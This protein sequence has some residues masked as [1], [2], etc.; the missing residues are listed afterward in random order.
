[1]IDLADRRAEGGH[2]IGGI[3]VEDAQKILVLKILLRLHAASGQEGV[4]DADGCGVSESRSDVE[5][6]IFLQKG[7]VNDGEDVRAVLVPV[8]ICKLRGHMLK[9][10]AKSIFAGYAKPLF[11]RG[12]NDALMLRLKLP[13]IGAAGLFSIASVC[14]V[15]Y[16]AQP[17]RFAGAVDN[18][19]T[20]ASAPD[21]PAH[22]LI[23]K[24]I[25][26]A[27]GGLRALGVDHK[28]LVVGVFV[29]PRSGSQKGRPLLIAAGDLARR[30]VCQLGIEL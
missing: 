25:L 18:S 10:V 22:A 20:T 27:G 13:E 9:L 1:M 11:Q 15:E 17:G 7:T 28:L 26:R 2:R 3:P 14:H 16:I 4:G 12:R 19:D 30:M 21:I 24:V 29:E 6:I 23:P 5:L 8:F